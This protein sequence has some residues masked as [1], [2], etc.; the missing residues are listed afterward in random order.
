MHLA[1]DGLRRLPHFPVRTFLVAMPPCCIL[2]S[3]TVVELCDDSMANVTVTC[4]AGLSQVSKPNILSPTLV[5]F[6]VT[7]FWAKITF[8]GKI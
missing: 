5:K 6:R 1:R 4:Y 3:V 7:Q 2:M 8:R